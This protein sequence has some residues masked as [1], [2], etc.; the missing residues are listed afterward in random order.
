M[1]KKAQFRLR[2][3][4]LLMAAIAVLFAICVQWPVKTF[5]PRRIQDSSGR[6]YLMSS[7]IE[8]PPTIQEWLIRVAISIPAIGI[9]ILLILV[10]YRGIGVTLPTWRTT[11]KD[12]QK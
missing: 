6:S 4:L 10:I 11:G 1:M 2:T 9:G 5:V 7:A 8:R 12:R 3:L